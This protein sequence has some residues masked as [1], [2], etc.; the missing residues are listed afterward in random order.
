MAII[1]KHVT[2]FSSILYSRNSEDFIKA[3]Q[4]IGRQ[5]ASRAGAPSLNP[6]RDNFLNKKEL[7]FSLCL[8][9]C[10]QTNLPQAGFELG[11]L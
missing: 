7:S 3:R 8:R 5:S 6:A 11:S 2:S 4:L 1:D 9:K 10:V